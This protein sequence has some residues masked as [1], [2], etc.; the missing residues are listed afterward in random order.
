MSN[1]A[2][3][4][5]KILTLGYTS[6]SVNFR[7]RYMVTVP[8][9]NGEIASPEH[10]TTFVLNTKFL[11]PFVCRY[12]F[13]SNKATV[14]I[15]CNDAYP[16][17]SFGKARIK[18]SR[19]LPSTKQATGGVNSVDKVQFDNANYMLVGISKDGYLN[20]IQP[21]KKLSTYSDICSRG[22][23]IGTLILTPPTF[24]SYR[25]ITIEERLRELNVLVS[26]G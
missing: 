26:T 17:I 11:E 3:P 19:L 21:V 12:W 7:N 8:G 22:T 20:E 16:L 6:H 2:Q 9:L 10:A 4:F 13:K 25:G 5:G 1:P 15:K 23:T 24:I 14:S 18:I